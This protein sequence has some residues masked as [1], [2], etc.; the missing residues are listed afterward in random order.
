MLRPRGRNIS[1]RHVYVVQP[2]NKREE[3]WMRS[4]SGPKG[5][6]R[7]SVSQ[8]TLSTALAQPAPAAGPSTASQTASAVKGVATDAIGTLAG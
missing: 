6:I 1:K 3:R 5:L 8:V 4:N 2:C 7:E